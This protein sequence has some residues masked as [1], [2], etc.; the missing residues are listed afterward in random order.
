MD[1]S[2]KAVVL[3]P[4]IGLS[5]D[6]QQRLETVWLSSWAAWVLPASGGQVGGMLCDALLCTG[7]TPPSEQVIWPQMPTVLLLRNLV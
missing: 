1:M 5:W 2:Y 3:S 7:Q 6:I 4:G